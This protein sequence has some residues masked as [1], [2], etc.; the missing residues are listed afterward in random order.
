MNK[1]PKNKSSKMSG[2]FRYG[3]ALQKSLLF[4]EAQR[5]GKLPDN[6][7]IEWRDDSALNDGKDVGRDLSG[8]YYDAGDHVKFG[9]PMASN[10]TMLAWGGLEFYDAY[11][12][13]GQLDELLDTIKWGADFFLKAHVTDA[14]GTKEF[15]TQVGDGTID[16]ATWAP[17]EEMTMKRPSYKVDRS[18]PGSDITGE[19]AASLA[20]SSMLFKKVDPEFADK[21][22][23]KYS[24]VIADNKEFYP[25]S[26]YND[27]LVW[28]AAWLY[29]A[30]GDKKYLKKAEDYHKKSGI[31][32]GDWT[33]DYNDKTYSY[34]ILLAD[35][36]KDKKYSDAVKK[37]L[38]TWVDGKGAVKHTPGG[39]AWRADWGSLN[40]AT[41]TAFLATVFYNNQPEGN[42]KYQDFAIQQV[43][44]ALGDNPNHFSYM[45]GF[46]NKYPQRVHHRGAHDRPNTRADFSSSRPNNH[47]LYGALTGGPLKP[48]DTSYH[49]KRD[50]VKGN[51]VATGYNAALSGALAALYDMMGGEALTDKELDALPGIR[52]VEERTASNLLA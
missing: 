1:S 50:N 17:P 25:S 20:A 11:K 27:E 2:K 22:R 48:D 30:T 9:L 12:K 28:G 39:L 10:L 49:D 45:I 29:K 7:R 43:N 40:M 36:T 46:G 24:D 44:Y 37:W 16:H 52:V 13:S 5:S 26:G 41:S 21:Y 14:K 51:E 47:I 33:A 38:D 18:K 32:L 35:L 34:H 42:K 19:T 31:Q 6:N 4:F 8:G 15:Y 23:G 3:E